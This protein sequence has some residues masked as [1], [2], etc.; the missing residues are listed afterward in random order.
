MRV[1]N[2]LYTFGLD[3][4]RYIM[5]A[6]PLEPQLAA[7]REAAKTRIPADHLAI[8]HAA[9]AEL[10]RSGLAA[11]AVGVGDRIPKFQLLNQTGNTV[12]SSAL[13]ARG[14]L[15]LTFFRGAW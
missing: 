5:E 12:D 10:Q 4:E 11:R 8:M 6:T 3:G 9:T 15:V 7:I 13:L 14:P 1:S 2:T